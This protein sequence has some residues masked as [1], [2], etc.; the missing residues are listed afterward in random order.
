MTTEDQK[1]TQWADCSH[2]WIGAKGQCL[3]CGKSEDSK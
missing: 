2:Y 1:T 3:L